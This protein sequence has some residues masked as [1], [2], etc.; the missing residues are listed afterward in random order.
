VRPI[1][2]LGGTFDPIHFGHLR[3]ALEIMRSL[4]L[5][6]VRLIPS[7]NPPHRSAPTAG[8]GERL[9]MVE[10]AASEIFG[11]HADSREVR[12]GGESF[13]VPTLESLRCELGSRPVC[14]IVG[15]DAFLGLESWYRSRELLEFAH[16]VVMQRPGWGSPPE[17]AALP[18]WLRGR[19]CAD[20]APLAN[21]PAGRLVFQAV[22]PQDISGSR[23]RA[24]LARGESVH[25]LLPAPVETFITSHGL[26]RNPTQRT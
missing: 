23:I 19:R 15:M 5:E 1:G 14:L 11:I 22:S 2:I 8:A 6:E 24:A 3:P 26:Y 16:L 9:R 7:A 10:L 18:S 21:A 13:T 4:G 17:D 20:S 25:G 12:R